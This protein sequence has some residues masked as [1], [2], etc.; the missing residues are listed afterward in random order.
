MRS[1]KVPFAGRSLRRQLILCFTVLAVLPLLASVLL[2]FHTNRQQIIRSRNQLANMDAQQIAREFDNV[3]SGY[4]DILYQLYTDDTLAALIENLN[5][6]EDVAVTRNQI[7]R[8]LRSV[9][10]LQDE[11]AS[12]SVVTKSGEM[13]FYDRLSY[14]Q[15]QN[16]SF[17]ALNLSNQELYDT[18]SDT[19]GTTYF[20]TQYVTYFGGEDH[21][22]FYVGHSMISQ[23]AISEVPAVI[24]MGINAE[25]FQETL[26][27]SMTAAD[28]QQYL[29]VLDDQQQ[30][31]WYPKM[32]F[33][34]KKVTDF[35]PDLLSFVRKH[36]EIE[37]PE[38]AVF[39]AE[40]ALTGWD[41]V[42]VLDCTPFTQAIDRQLGITIGIA[43][44]SFALVIGLVC[45]ITSR[46]TRSVQEICRVMNIVSGG[47][48]NVRV[49][50]EAPMAT[51]VHTIARGLNT[52]A[53]RLQVLIRQEQESLMKVKNAE[54]AALEAQ[55]NPH[56]LYNTLDTI[57]W[58]AIAREEYPISNVI[59]ALG[60]VL[61][62][63]I[64]HSNGVVTLA[65]EEN[66]LKQYL[67]IHQNRM[68]S[69]FACDIH[70]DPELRQCKIH[71]L[72]FQ[73]FIENAM[74][75]G[76]AQKK[77]DCFLEVSASREGEKLR[78]DIRD[79]GCGIPADVMQKLDLA[80]SS[81]ETKKRYRGMQNA[82]NRL[83]LYY[84]DE[85][86]FT[87]ESSEHSG[88]HVSIKVPILE[89]GQEDAH[90]DH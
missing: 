78:M 51:E 89:G 61:R 36:H 8:E 67:F 56:F 46:I 30:F 60:R 5:Q 35:A 59:S 27:K 84:G 57:N 68:K 66:W 76:F 77:T 26:S 44:L 37:S 38:L 64:D 41:M 25:L 4:E 18:I 15:Q 28:Q 22:L 58:M 80:Q 45:G 42:Y 73:P 39:H 53:D 47:D 69:G 6:G 72:L 21:H 2:S 70:I 13:A 75:H 34:Q 32:D 52:M 48:L 74:I 31:I 86:E 11:I 63:G 7:R 23:Q 83:L 14:A 79:N 54:I 12:I 90:R 43:L 62:Y 1:R 20:P 82:L 9:F 17:D 85:A 71:K 87:I 81:I 55:L 50:L 88:T 49:S 40:S 3:L 19:R 33:I 16:I 29:F 24:I 10:W 65:E